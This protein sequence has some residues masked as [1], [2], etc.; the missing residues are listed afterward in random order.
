[1]AAATVLLV[2][3]NEDNVSIYDA[4]LTHAGYTVLVAKDGE[5]A[6]DVVRREQPGLILMDISIPKIDGWEVTRRLKADP[7]TMAIPIIALTAHALASDRAMAETVG[8]D[9]YIPKPAD[10]IQVLE[11]VQRRLGEPARTGS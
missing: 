1:M 3:D 8:C 4:I 6:L 5:A 9:G 10:P 2:E 7:A 11:E